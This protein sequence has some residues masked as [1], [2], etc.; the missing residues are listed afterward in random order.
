VK[1]T[2]DER[3]NH[4]WHTR[5]FRGKLGRTSITRR[6]A[7]LFYRKAATVA[8]NLHEAAAASHAARQSWYGIVGSVAVRFTR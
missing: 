2:W 7:C 6:I 1:L 8:N 5:H 3:G 4:S